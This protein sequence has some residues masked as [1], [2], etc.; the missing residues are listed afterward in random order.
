MGAPACEEEDEAPAEAEA[1]P[2]APDEAPLDSE[3]PED[4]APPST[5]VLPM[6]VLLPLDTV[7]TIGSVV[8]GVDFVPAPKIV[9]VFT[10]VVMVLLPDVMVENSVEVVMALLFA[11]G[12]EVAPLI[13]L[14]SA[15]RLPEALEEA[16]A[17]AAGF[18][19]ASCWRL[20]GGLLRGPLTSLAI[21][22]TPCKNCAGICIRRAG[23]DNTV[24]NAVS[25]VDVGAEAE[26]VRCAVR[27]VGAV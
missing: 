23:F 25:E 26:R 1:E 13:E 12:T 4:D 27:Q 9:V 7:E 17:A 14:V 24:M 2:D 6:V 18:Q 20:N 10:P 19:L 15:V 16:L 21:V 5:V 3:A 11:P 22:N 8:M